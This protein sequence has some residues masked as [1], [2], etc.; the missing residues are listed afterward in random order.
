MEYVRESCG[1]WRE[2]E[3]YRCDGADAPAPKRLSRN[4]APSADE[5]VVPGMDFVMS[6]LAGRARPR[7]PEKPPGPRFSL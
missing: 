7:R 2:R 1:R 3:K 5:P 6:E 4:V